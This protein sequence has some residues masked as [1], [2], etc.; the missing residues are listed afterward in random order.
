MA[1]TASSS[2]RS[3]DPLRVGA[4]GFEHALN[5]RQ[6]MAIGTERP[7]S[8]LRVFFRSLKF[9]S[10]TWLTAARPAKFVLCPMERKPRWPFGI[11]RM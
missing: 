11:K 8:K 4:D 3:A 7:A 6:I 5:R 9:R 2:A 10:V 1:L